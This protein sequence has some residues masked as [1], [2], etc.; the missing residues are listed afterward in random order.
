MITAWT[1]L[2]RTGP[3]PRGAP[4]LLLLVRWAVVFAGALG[5]PAAPAAAQISRGQA[6]ILGDSVIP[7]DMGIGRSIPMTT[8][9]PIQRVSIANPEVADI[10][11]I[12]EREL[13][14]NALAL[15]LTDLIIWQ[16]DGRRFHYRVS[17]HSA[18]DRKQVL[19]QV[20]FAEV[21]TDF[22][23]E[24]GSSFLFK[25]N[26]RKN[27]LGT[28]RF[29]SR[30]RP[31][32]DEEEV[33]IRDLGQFATFLSVGQVENLTALFDAAEQSGDFRLLAEPNLLAADGEEASF[34]AG[35][36]IPVPIAQP[37]GV[38]GAV[39][40]SIQYREFGVRLAFLPEILSEDLI[41]LRIEPEVSALDFTNAITTAGFQ[42]PAFRTRRTSTTI[43]M[44]TGQT[45]AISG[46]FDSRLQKLKVGI[47]LLKDIPILGL[48]FSSQRFEREETELLVL[49]QPHIIDPLAPAQPPALPGEEGRDGQLGDRN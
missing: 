4:V 30:A 34:L 9:A 39:T 33:T 32:Q 6:V 38:G 20:R 19:L 14:V 24:L 41:K 25:D 36:E 18:T 22:L 37:S 48:L 29:S 28:G 10:V 11:L 21:S 17:V 2:H 49:V 3:R 46:L 15:G 40:I 13:V 44:R 23:R 45:L 1:S 31:G 8:A 12:A 43:D 26:D 47:P 5:G 35:G 7:L 42:I 27:R 16:I